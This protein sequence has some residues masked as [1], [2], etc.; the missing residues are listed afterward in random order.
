METPRAQAAAKVPTVSYQL[1]SSSMQAL[2]YTLHEVDN[3]SNIISTLGALSRRFLHL[4]SFYGVPNRNAG[5]EPAQNERRIG[6]LFQRARSLKLNSHL[7]LI[8]TDGNTSG[9]RF[10]QPTSVAALKED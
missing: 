7:V 4:I 5:P 2:L 8:C 9:D 10:F 3:R 1:G 6:L